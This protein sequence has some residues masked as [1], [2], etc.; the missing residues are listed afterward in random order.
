[1]QSYRALLYTRTHKCALTHTYT[2]SDDQVSQRW[3]R[4]QSSVL[5]AAKDVGDWLRGSDV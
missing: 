4:Y 2:D 3:V 1:M 5:A